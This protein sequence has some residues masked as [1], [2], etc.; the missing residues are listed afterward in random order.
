[1]ENLFISNCPERRI[2]EKVARDYPKRKTPKPSMFIQHCT[3]KELG[4]VLHMTSRFTIEIV[5][6]G[7]LN[8][9]G[10]GN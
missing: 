9:L 8:N 2:R 3:Y 6:R 1:L 7:C 10:S 4:Y 5:T